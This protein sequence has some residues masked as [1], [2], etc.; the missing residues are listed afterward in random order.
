[1]EGR[2]SSSEALIEAGL[3]L[4]S[5]LSLPAILQ[6]IVELACSVAGARYG[7]LGILT[8]EGA[9]LHDFITVG[10]TDAEREAIG[11]LPRGHGILGALIVEAKPLRLLRIQDDP[12]SVGFPANHPP[13]TSFLGVPIKARGRVFGNLYL[14]E[15]RGAPEFSAEDERA[16]GTLAAQAGVAIENAGMREELQRMA[17]TEDRER[18]AKELHDGV[19]QSLFAVGMSLAATA[20][21][22]GVSSEAHARMSAAVDDIDKVIRDL[23]GYIFALRPGEAADYHVILA[24]GELIDSM[25]RGSSIA[26]E[27]D[28][29]P[30]VAARISNKA[31]HVLQAAREA[32]SNAVRHSGAATVTLAL[33]DESGRTVLEVRDDGRGFDPS[34]P[35]DGNGLRNL[36]VRAAELGGT[37]DVETAAGKGTIVRLTIP[38]A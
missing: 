10:I 36:R 18:I 34:N 2:D 25:R 17:I 7:A 23:R 1:V 12:R 16:V 9:E 33:R 3:V 4:A 11:A 28:V 27:A 29:D 14:T 31:A 26:I 32:L 15:K 24:I 35:A 6:K 37:L 30:D 22:T 21:M 19:I 13:M 5:E 20:Q 38:P 8:P